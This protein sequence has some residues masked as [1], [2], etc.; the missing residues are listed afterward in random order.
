M[1]I[2]DGLLKALDLIEEV[3]ATIRASPAAD[4]AHRNLVDKFG[5]TDLQADAILKMQ[6]R[7][8]AA[9]EQQK[10]LDE[11]TG[12]QTII[13]RLSWILSSDQNI[14]SVVKEETDE[15]RE[16]FGDERRTRI[17]YSTN[18]D[19]DVL[20]LIE[21]KQVLVMLTEGDYIKRMP[22]DSC[23]QQQR[24]GRGV[25]GMTTKDEDSVDK[26]YLASMHDYLL[27]F[28]NRG[29]LY[30]LRVHELPEGSRQ[31]KGK[32]IV[33]L[34]NLV[35]ED[36]SAVIPIREFE[37]NKYLFFATKS[38]RVAK[39][40]QKLFSH[41]RAG[42][43]NAITILDGDELVDVVV[44]DGTSDVVLTTWLGQSLRFSELTVRPTTGRGTQGVIGIR[45]KDSR[46][47]LCALTL[48]EKDY[49]LTVTEGGY[50]K[51]TS[52]E[53]FRGK[54]RGGMGIRNIA[55]DLERGGVVSS[56]AIGNSDEVVITTS[57]GVVMRTAAENISVQGRGT[58]GVRII[59]V[60]AGD[61]VASIAVVPPEDENPSEN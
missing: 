7:R 10:I 24:G 30:W 29:R 20:D 21:D 51:R 61:K 9:L 17:D 54:G 39:M 48:V 6:L 15:V 16:L 35:D 49:M 50:G 11:K 2:L 58:R 27:F 38:G 57:G 23:R 34:L 33:N 26:V 43:I 55:T 46:D 41:P 28:T 31:S 13:D 22:L 18:T 53:A 36:V 5:F 12:L 52:F 45:F 56:L 59:R 47:R 37:E 4:V 40:P 19:F 3:V 1:H 60:D 14:L 32:A 42:G 25:T 8:L 44:T